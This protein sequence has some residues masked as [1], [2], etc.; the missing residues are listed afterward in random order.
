MAKLES[1]TGLVDLIYDAALEPALWNNVLRALGDRIGGNCGWIS[2]INKVDGSGANAEDW[3]YGI[4]PVAGTA[5]AEYFFRLNPFGT[6]AESMRRWTPSISTFESEMPREALRRTE[7][8]ADFLRPQDISSCVMIRLARLDATSS[9]EMNI[10]CSFRRDR[11]DDADIEFV[12]ALHP[13]MFRAFGL[14]R[15]LAAE[16]LTAAAEGSADAVFVLDENGRV[17]RLNAAA[18]LMSRRPDA[19]RVIGGRLCADNADVARRLDGMIRRALTG[20]GDA[21]GGGTLA[22]ATPAGPR[23]IQVTVS[24]VNA[25]RALPHRVGRAAIVC[26]TDLNAPTA[27]RGE[28]LQAL[29]GLTPAEIRVALAIAEGES[30]AVAAERFGVSF[31]TVRNQL[32]RVYDKTATRGQADLAGLIWRLSASA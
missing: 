24:P 2:Q 28:R 17:Q 29:F 4:D 1:V 21:R 32:T 11:F 6:N 13:H 12:R 25:E 14:G 19:L 10:N 23:P 31:Q 15:R 8:G 3:V 30:P 7:F 16:R 5:Y 18:K 20:D 27:L 22:L 26:A 9:A